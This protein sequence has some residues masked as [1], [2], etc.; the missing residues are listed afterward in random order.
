MTSGNAGQ[1][2]GDGAWPQ[3][4]DLRYPQKWYMFQ[5]GDGENGS[6]KGGVRKERVWP[7][8]TLWRFL[9]I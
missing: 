1:N 8:S 2:R 4:Q 3:E 7:G 5:G 6:T 9:P